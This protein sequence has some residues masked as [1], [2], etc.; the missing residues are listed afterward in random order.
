MKKILMAMLPALLCLNLSAQTFVPPPY[1]ETS[2]NHQQYV[3]YTFGALETNRIPTGLLLDYAFDFTEPKIYNGKTQADSTLIEQGI[4]SELYKTIYTSR[5]SNTAGTFR[6]PS[7]H[8]SLCYVARQQGVIT[9]SGLMFRYNA[10]DPNAQANG[11]I[12][13]V[14]GQLKDVYTRG[15]WQNPYQEFTTLAISPSITRYSRTSCQVK[16]PSNLFLNNMPRQIGS[17]EF[18][19][20]NGLGYRN[21]LFDSTMT[22]NYADTGWR[23]WVFRVTLNDGRIFYTHS[24]VHFSRESSIGG[25]ATSRAVIDQTVRIIAAEAF[26][27]KF[28]EADII[29]SRRDAGDA[30][31]RRPLIIAE[32]FDPGHI[33]SPEALEGENTFADF[34]R[35]VVNSQSGALQNL[36][37]GDPFIFNSPSEYDIIYVNWKNGTDYLQRNML[38][39]EEVIR[40]VNAN[41][42]PLF[43]VMQPNVVLGSSMGGVI[44]RMALGRMDRN[45]GAIAHQTNLF[46][47]LDAPQ[48]G[49]NVPLGYQAAA[50]HALKIYISTGGL[51][52]AVEIV[53]LLLNG[54]SPLM[55]LLLSDQP[56][57]RQL[58]T[59]RVNFFYNPANTTNQQFMEE[60]RTQWP[61]PAN[62]RN[63]AISNGNE[64]AVDQEFAPNSSLLYHHRSTKTRFIGDLIFMV[65]GAG[66]TGLHLGPLT[67][68]TIPFAIPGSNRF[69]FTMDVKT[70]ANGGSNA[71]YYGNINYTKKVLWLAPVTITIAN[72]TYNAPGGLLP[73]DTYPGGFYLNTMDNQPGA[74][75]QD[76]MFTYDN[77]FFIQRRFCFI[78]TTS[79][80]DIGQGNV[81]LGNNDY[82]RRY[83][84]QTPPAAPL[85]T[86][87]D[88][89]ATAFNTNNART[90]FTNDDLRRLN[91]EPHEG[92]FVRTSN[93]LAQ[94]L[95]NNQAVRTNCSAFC[96]EASITGA[97]TICTT[98]TYTAPF[99]VGATYNWTITSGSN[100]VTW[101]TTNNTITITRNPGA[102]GQVTMR[103]NINGDC[104]I[105]TYNRTV[106]VGGVAEGIYNYTSNSSVGTSGLGSQNTHFLGAGQ[107]MG[108]TA[109]LTNTN[110]TG[111]TWTNSG[112][113]VSFT[114]NG[115]SVAFSMSAAQ[116]AYASRTTTFTANGTSPC[117]THSQSYSFTIVTAPWLRFNIIT[118]PNPAKDMVTVR[119]EN[120]A[121]EV[122]KLGADATVV[123]KLY[124]FNNP[125]LARQW[126]YKNDRKT[127]YLNITGLLKGQ[128]ILKVTKA[129]YTETRQLIVE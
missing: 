80:L 87:F 102:N 37:S 8:D 82:L 39:L 65:G 116:G 59:N 52:G 69:E 89:F 106:N 85:N 97:A 20:D 88:N 110:L 113:P 3:D 77:S 43:G 68:I 108:F 19:A 81:A 84:G 24:K 10:I 5:I 71:V 125:I 67:G 107:S 2:T 76:W 63:V 47:S 101:T 64:C 83:I 99:G 118:S 128:Y 93:W 7:I 55:S 123:F 11:T 33:T 70:L 16:L 115:A 74:A 56:A 41:K 78:P 120:E 100:L 127:Y 26:Q 53:Q 34:I 51:A 29:I 92:L 57:A 129:K 90:R 40:W 45:G 14:N 15:A 61:Y 32:G 79:A 66:L 28:G 13:T 9:L 75:F 27:G 73:L 96:A 119:L 46:V 112:F 58:L 6:H 104:G 94:E 103:V 35:T 122:K 54:P 18:D 114:P 48:Q 25:G 62:I 38:V 49:A 44:A 126:I 111:V 72:K 86:P 60:L 124:N 95:I 30:F 12:Q 21:L 98:E 4:Y 23:H 31:I 91:N 121:D 1:A 22:L 50:R 105:F 17:I 109:N 117:G 42:Q 36:V